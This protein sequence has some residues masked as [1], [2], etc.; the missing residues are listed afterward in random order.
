MRRAASIGPPRLEVHRHFEPS[1][2]AK[3][4]QAR[5]YELVPVGRRT[6][7]RVGVADPRAEGADR[8]GVEVVTQGGVAA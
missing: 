5:A 1:R 3:E 4:C 6:P 7:T 8:E 2:L